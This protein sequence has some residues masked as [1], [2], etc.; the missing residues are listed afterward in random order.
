MAVSRR[1]EVLRTTSAVWLGYA[2]VL[3]DGNLI[4]E[5]SIETMNAPSAK[6]IDAADTVDARAADS[7][8]HV[9]TA[10]DWLAMNLDD[11]VAILESRISRKRSFAPPPHEREISRIEQCG[12]QGSQ[13]VELVPDGAFWIG[14]VIYRVRDR[15]VEQDRHAQT[16]TEHLNG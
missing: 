15:T 13:K 8:G 5:I 16:K 2:S 1:T 3:V 10:P 4:N 14:P 11:D 6:V 9:V 12:E 7:A